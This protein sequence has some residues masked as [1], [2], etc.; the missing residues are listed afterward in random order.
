MLGLYYTAIKE[1]TPWVIQLFFVI[2]II[3]ALYV[4][5]VPGN[6]IEA[7][8]SAKL[9]RF[10]S[11]DGIGSVT[12]LHD[13]FFVGGFQRKEIPF[14]QPFKEAPQVEL[15]KLSGPGSVAHS[16]SEITVHKFVVIA[17]PHTL[18][19]VDAQYRWIATGTLLP[20]VKSANPA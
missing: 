16:V 5:F 9:Q 2:T 13:E 10:Q 6:R 18:S 15:I 8:V 12:K 4:L 7:N 19:G 20:R 17:S 1:P 11:P 3:F 14:P